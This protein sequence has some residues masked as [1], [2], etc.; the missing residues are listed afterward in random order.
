VAPLTP[1][2]PKLSREL[3]IKLTYLLTQNWIVPL[4]NDLFNLLYHNI[5]KYILSQ[6]SYFDVLSVEHLHS[7]YQS[8]EVMKTISDSLIG[9]TLL[10]ERPKDLESLLNL[11]II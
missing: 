8:P 7:H 9:E 6:V 11:V 10:N 5:L 2:L 1:F 3:P 4:F